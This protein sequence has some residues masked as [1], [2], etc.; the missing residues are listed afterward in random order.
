MSD[1]TK[2]IAIFFSIIITEKELKSYVFFWVIKVISNRLYTQKEH[3][4]IVFLVN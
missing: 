2:N 1:C 4:R 3:V